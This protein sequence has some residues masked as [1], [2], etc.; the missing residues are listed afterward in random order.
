MCVDLLKPEVLVL[1]KM[2]AVL[3][4]N[5]KVRVQV[6]CKLWN[7]NLYE[8][9]N[10]MKQLRS[11][12]LILQS[13]DRD[14]KIYLYEI[15]CL[16]MNYLRTSTSKDALSKLH[17]DVLRSYNYISET[18]V[19]VEIEDDGYIAYYVGYHLLNTNNLNNAWNMFR[20]LYLDLK[21][22]GYKARLT[23]IADVNLD[24]Q[25]YETHIVDDVSILSN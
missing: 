23:G 18:E 19:P 14:Q 21:F 6:F 22:I 24:L 16:I 8:V 3:P 25:K 17:L 5:V 4:D 12:S 9:E 15:D 7:K 13:Y 10:I 2:L 1:F 20:K 11:K